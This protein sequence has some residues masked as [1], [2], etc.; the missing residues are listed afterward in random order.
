MAAQLAAWKVARWDDNWVVWKALTLAACL[1][2][3][4]VVQMVASMVALVV[5]TMDGLMELNKV[6]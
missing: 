5:D 4:L 6:V 2:V 3:K 1:A